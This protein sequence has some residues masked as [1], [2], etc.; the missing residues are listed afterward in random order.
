MAT[1]HTITS[2]L[3]RWERG[4]GEAFDELLPLLYE[5]LRRLAGRG[6]GRTDATLSPT[7]LVHEAYLR[8]QAQGG[9]FEDRSHFF[10]A[11]ALAMRRL[12]VD[13]A[14]ARARLKRGG[15]DLRVELEEDLAGDPAAEPAEGD[16]RGIDVLALDQA[17]ERLGTLD[18]RKLRIVQLRY[19]GGLTYDETA[20]VLGLSPATVGRELRFARAWLERE[21]AAGGRP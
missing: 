8:F 18:E 21:L 9:S 7:A 1:G 12:L 4:N 10:A 15:G 3:H 20:D 19:F 14:R 17:L 11:A 16:P 2:L 13:H 6:R 5:E